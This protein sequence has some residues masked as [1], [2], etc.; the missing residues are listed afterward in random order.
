MRLFLRLA[1]RWPPWTCDRC[2]PGVSRLSLNQRPTHICLTQIPMSRPG[3]M[4]TN[5][6]LRCPRS[7]VLSL[8][9]LQASHVMHVAGEHRFESWYACDEGPMCRHCIKQEPTKL[10]IRNSCTCGA[11]KHA[12]VLFHIPTNS[13]LD[14]LP[15]QMLNLIH[16]SRSMQSR[17]TIAD[18]FI[19]DCATLWFM[20]KKLLFC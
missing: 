7:F 3:R 8:L 13:T 5:L 14:Y 11:Y 6:G 15:R 19:I 4:Y 17:H 18:A 2:L 1:D 20:L 12:A 10:L 9:I 16:V